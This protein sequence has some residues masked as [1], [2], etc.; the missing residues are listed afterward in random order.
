MPGRFTL[1][2]EEEFQLVNRRT[3]QLSSGVNSVLEKGTPYLEEKIKP[4]LTQSTIE[5]ISDICPDIT[6][7]RTELYTLRA[8]LARLVNEEGLALIS[9]G[10]HPTSEWQDQETTDKERYTELEEEFQ[11]VIRSNIIFGLHVHVGVDD[12]EQSVRLMNQ[13]R[14]WLPQLLALSTNSPFW[15]SRNTGIKSY[16]S[17]LWR[18]VHRSG[19]PEIIE[20]WSE[21]E[22]YVQTLVEMGCIDN[23]KK[24]WWDV[25]PH[26]FFDTIEFRVCD[27]PATIEDTLAIV[28]F[29]QALIAKLA[30]CDEHNV[31]IPILKRDYIEENKWRAM[32]YGLDAEVL[33]F[34]HHRRLS[35]REAINETLDFVDDMVDDLG[36][37][38]EITYLCAL[39]ANPDG[40]GADRQIAM[41]EQTHDIKK[42]VELLMEQTMQGI[43]LDAA[44][45]SHQSL[46]FKMYEE[47]QQVSHK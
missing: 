45:L 9:A 25:R 18:H 24:I 15:H 43:T 30:W 19:L 16:R 8:L 42:V 32:R 14:T 39:L 3:L 22:Q 36:S 1:G 29:C 31:A 13:A 21:F 7:A 10:T 34:V 40:T 28:A 26:P 33:D 11:D 20:S 38:Q 44:D 27:M 12:K 23:G 41:Y 17:A 5:L 37:R 6:A 4:E 2:I 46:K 47:E 35:M